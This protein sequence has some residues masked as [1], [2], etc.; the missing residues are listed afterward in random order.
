MVEYYEK[1]FQL[2]SLL[3]P[4]VYQ[5]FLWCYRNG[6]ILHNDIRLK[7]SYDFHNNSL[8]DVSDRKLFFPDCACK[9]TYFL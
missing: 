7:Y 4:K 6:I 1:I 2:N 9:E 5:Y 8:W 3:Y